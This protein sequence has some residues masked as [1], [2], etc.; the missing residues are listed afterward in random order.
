MAYTCDL[1]T[2]EEEAGGSPQLPVSLVYRVT[3]H[4]QN[5]VYLWW[6][7]LLSLCKLL[8]F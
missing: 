1:S 4:L 8:I 6:L 7:S 2:G 5:C 3:G